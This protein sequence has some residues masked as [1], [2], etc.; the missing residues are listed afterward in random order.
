MK[1]PENDF[2]K[3]LSLALEVRKNAYAPYSNYAVGAALMSSGGEI[4]TGVNVENAAFA[5]TICAERSAV[6]N[7]VSKGERDFKA[8]VVVTENG[9][10][11]CGACRQALSEFAKDAEVI[12]ANDQG[13]IVLETT[14]SEL[15][16]YSFGQKDLSD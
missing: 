10:V 5:I 11:S 1:L 4:F 16:P 6:F 7:A 15:L 9:G 14:V 13:E 12:I 3:L 8:I 2:K